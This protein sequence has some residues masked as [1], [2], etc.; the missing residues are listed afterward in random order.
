[1]YLIDLLFF[2][3]CTN[4]RL[5]NQPL[6]TQQFDDD[7]DNL[8][9]YNFF[10]HMSLD[11]FESSFGPTQNEGKADAANLLFIQD[12]IEVYGMEMLTGLKVVVGC[13]QI[14]LAKPQVDLGEVMNE[15]KSAY[16]RVSSNPFY[17]EQGADLIDNEKFNSRIKGIVAKFNASD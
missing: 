9:K 5:Q 6:Y 10:S 16:V 4:Q 2:W 12:G 7:V 13:S 15:I 17:Q 1:M 8:L 11:I 3:V 14:S